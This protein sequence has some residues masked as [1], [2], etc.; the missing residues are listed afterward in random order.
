MQQKTGKDKDVEKRRG[1]E[2]CAGQRVEVGGE[3]VQLFDETND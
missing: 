2:Q 3:K 1:L